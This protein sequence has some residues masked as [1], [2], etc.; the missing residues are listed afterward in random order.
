MTKLHGT[1][2]CLVYYQVSSTS[3]SRVEKAITRTDAQQDFESWLK[4]KFRNRP[5]LV[6]ILLKVVLNK[7]EVFVNQKID[8]FKAS[9]KSTDSQ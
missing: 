1:S 6:P 2:E 7:V 9:R 5:A 8:E 3:L 4:V